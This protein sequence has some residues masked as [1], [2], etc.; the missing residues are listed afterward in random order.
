MT[1][2]VRAPDRAAA[3][4]VRRAARTGYRWL[5]L[6]FLLAVAAQ[7]FLAGLGTFSF[8]TD[9]QAGGEHAFGAHQGLGFALAGA[10]VLILVLALAARPGR[11]ALWLAAAL[12]VQ[13]CLLQSLLDGLADHTVLFGRLHALDGLLI[14]A[15]AA[16]QYAL[17]RRLAAQ[18]AGLRP[19]IGGRGRGHPGGGMDQGRRGTAA[20]R[21]L[22]VRVATV[23]CGGADRG[24]RPPPGRR[25][26]GPDGS[27]P[28][29]GRPARRD[30][31]A[32]AAPGGAE[33]RRGQPAAAP[34][35]P[36]GPGHAQRA[37]HRGTTGHD[38][39][40]ACVPAPAG[41]GPDAERRKIERN[42]HDGAQQQLIAL[43]IQLGL[44]ADSADDP[45]MVRKAIP[46]LKAQLGTAL[47][48]LRA[49]ARGIYPPLLAE[50]GLVMALRAQAARS[51][52]PV[53]VEADQVGRYPQEAESTVYFCML[54]AMQNVAKHARASRATVRLS[55]SGQGLTF[56]ISD[57]GTGFPAA[58]MRHGSGL[59][60]MSDRLA[61]HGGALDLRSQP[62]RGTTITGWL[63]APERAAVVGM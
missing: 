24:R 17:A 63:P 54:E 13:T 4:G 10:S 32:Q 14:A 29:R 7:I 34:G 30:L 45:D 49:L 35:L 15:N 46:D 62:G 44:L 53:Q 39:R 42:L 47:D 20:R 43:A 22:A 60:G 23:R 38:R 50:Q 55:G 18:H 8:D 9:R 57:D 37:A 40:A 6:T 48:D 11:L 25:R 3:S 51:P 5:L 12:V 31:A 1:A 2:S 61:A 27:G 41:G 21:R 16:V 36:G 28:A 52:V 19:A 33:Q 56:S 59:Q 26:P 58:G